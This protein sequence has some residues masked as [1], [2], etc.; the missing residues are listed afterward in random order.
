MLGAGVA[1]IALEQAIPFSRVWS[2]PKK[3]VVPEYA[4]FDVGRLDIRVPQRFLITEG[5]RYTAYTVNQKGL[6]ENRDG[7]GWE[8]V[9]HSM[10]DVKLLVDP[11]V[12]PFDD[13]IFTRN[14]CAKSATPSSPSRS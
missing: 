10:P 12:I 1:G 13:E 2:F 9:S 7:R 14:L 3:I 5:L 4:G 6:Y 11:D 8:R